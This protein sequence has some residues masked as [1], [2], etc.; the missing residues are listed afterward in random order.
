MN[1]PFIAGAYLDHGETVITYY[2]DAKS[3][4]EHLKNLTIPELSHVINSRQYQKTVRNAAARTLKKLMAT[5]GT[6][7]DRTLQRCK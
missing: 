2:T 1:D 7:S 4:I 5:A 3:R 6:L